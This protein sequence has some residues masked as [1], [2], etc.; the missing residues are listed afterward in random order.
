[1]HEKTKCHPA[2]AA[3]TVV[4]IGVVL[5]CILASS[6]VVACRPKTPAA[7]SRPVSPP[8]EVNP[9]K[10]VAPAVPKPAPAV[11]GPDLHFGAPPRWNPGETVPDVEVTVHNNKD[12]GPASG[13]II[14]SARDSTGAHVGERTIYPKTPLAGDAVVCVQVVMT[15]KPPPGTLLTIS[16]SYAN[17]DQDQNPSDNATAFKVP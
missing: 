5:G 2:C 15:S 14:V 3:R 16:L 6:G 12:A 8:Y 9:D 17:E 13:P 1:M 7:A 4:R 11:V 10:R